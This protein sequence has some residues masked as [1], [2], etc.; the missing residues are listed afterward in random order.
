MERL[1]VTS[2]TIGKWVQAVRACG[3]PGES[4]RRMD[5]TDRYAAYWTPEAVDR[6]MW[7]A[8]SRRPARVHARH[9]RGASPRPRNRWS[10][11]AGPADSCAAD[12]GR[13]GRPI[14]GF[15]RGWRS[16][17]CSRPRNRRSGRGA[18]RRP[19][20]SRSVSRRGR[21]P[22][23]SAPSTT[24]YSGL[25]QPSRTPSRTI[26]CQSRRSAVV[27]PPHVSSRPCALRAWPPRVSPDADLSMPPWPVERLELELVF[28]TAPR[29]AV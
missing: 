23:G 24:P 9:C 13:S 27:V 8:Q 5:S 1:L 7:A 26:R 10:R 20:S 6:G 3:R 15:G 28:D 16:G 14:A 21:H 11:A 17:P 4:I 25:Y 18:H 29:A 19:V 2:A 22:W 12:D